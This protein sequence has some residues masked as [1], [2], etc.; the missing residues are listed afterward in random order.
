MSSPTTA[1][2]APQ[3]VLPEPPLGRP[4]ALPPLWSVELLD[5]FGRRGRVTVV[6]AAALTALALVSAVAAPGLVP[7]RAIVGV[8]V[9]ITALAVGMA[10]TLAL[11]ALDVRIR[12][13]RH[14]RSSGGELVALLPGTATTR[15]AS[16]LADAVRAVQVPGTM[17]HLGLAPVGE[18]LTSAA[19]W[20]RVL[21][22]SLADG[23]ASV[24]LV[25]IATGPT[26]GPGIAEV[27]RDRTPLS[28]VVTYVEG[29]SLAVAGPGPDRIQ[30]LQALI[31]LPTVLPG[32]V[33]VLLVAL[34]QIVTRSAVNASRVLDQ[35]LF[36]AEANL[37][38]RVELMA[39]LD[40]LRVAGCSPQVVLVDD[41]TY[42]AL[43][44]DTLSPARERESMR[45]APVPFAGPAAG[46]ASV[47]AA[48][49]AP[50]GVGAGAASA[51]AALVAPMFASGHEP[52]SQSEPVQAPGTAPE[53]EAELEPQAAEEVDAGPDVDPLRSAGEPSS[54]LRTV[55]VLEAAAREQAETTL[56]AALV[57]TMP[58]D[59]SEVLAPPS[60]PT[61]APT[62]APTAGPA[63][64]PVV[65]PAPTP[66]PTLSPAPEPV[67]TTSTPSPSTPSTAAPASNDAER[68]TELDVTTAALPPWASPTDEE[69]LLRTTVQMSVFSEELD[70]RDED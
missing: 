7:P 70:L 18:D 15:D 36:V 9:A 4:R 63:P 19:A 35:V 11:D 68:T 60:L 47:A 42:R 53:P 12:G 61:P 21:A 17:L 39:S 58:M 26:D 5:V 46:A 8:L 64:T 14:V 34:P 65:P 44:P 28:A 23:G 56:D 67:R 33:D 59:R 30:A 62:A 48:A 13:P 55:D 32:D 37:S 54:P 41:G 2:S 40:A 45:I 16:D 29:R 25:D 1:S 49:S 57:D 24:L 27:V 52:S 20:T 43:R 22:E 51:A 10:L 31:T 3:S 66:V 6:V 38:S 69:D 50:L